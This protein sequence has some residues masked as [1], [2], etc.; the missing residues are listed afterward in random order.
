MNRRAPS[1]ESDLLSQHSNVALE[2]W[3]FKV[4]AGPVALLVDWIAR[5]DRHERTLRASVHSP[6]G[7][8]VL[9]GSYAAIDS[10]DQVLTQNRTCGR[11]GMLEWDLSIDVGPERLIPQIFPAAQLHMF[12]LT[13]V[14][15]PMVGF[16]GWMRHGAD[17][18]R[19]DRAPGILSHYWG[20]KLPQDWWWVSASQFDRPGMVLEAMVLHS[21]LWGLPV[22]AKLGYLYLRDADGRRFW[23]APPAAAHVYGSPEAFRVEFQDISGRKIRL[24]ATGRDYGDFG[25]GISNTSVG[26]LEV[27]A[28]G[29]LLGSA[30]GTAGLERRQPSGST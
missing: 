15:A 30:R 7:R 14:S 8:E 6:A 27:Y 25:A 9:Y 29:E 24:L 21:G 2:Y 10:G 11:L 28:G 3:F 19:F 16:S 13:L 18:Y 20:R 12:D 22:R 23:I 26:D 5:R 4:N 1:G 17:R